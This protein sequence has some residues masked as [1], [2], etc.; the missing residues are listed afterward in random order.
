MRLFFLSHGNKNK[1][2]KQRARCAFQIQRSDTATPPKNKNAAPRA[3]LRQRELHPRKPHRPMPL[4]HGAERP[5]RVAKSSDISAM[6]QSALSTPRKTAAD[7]S[8]T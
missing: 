2:K 6:G 3:N 4:K 7:R 8:H 1:Q 5:L